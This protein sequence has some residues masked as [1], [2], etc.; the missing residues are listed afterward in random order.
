[1]T[2][3]SLRVVTLSLLIAAL[4]AGGMPAAVSLA[5]WGRRPS[6]AER[7]KHRH[8]RKYSRAWWRR[9]RA[10]QRA[11]R[12]RATARRRRLEAQRNTNSLA[13]RA[14]R[15]PPAEATNSTRE[16]N[17][18]AARSP[19]AALSA[20][21][22]D[23]SPASLTN[24]APRTAPYVALP[25]VPNAALSVPPPALSGAP[26][27]RAAGY[28]RAPA[29]GPRMPFEYAAPPSW[30]AGRRAASGA[31]QFTL[32]TPSGRPAGTATLAPVNLARDAGEGPAAA[33][34]SIGGVSLAVLRRTVID[35]M[36]AEGGW[37]TNDYVR[38]IDGRRVF[39]VFAQT[40]SP[41]APTQSQIFY[42]TEVDGR[43]Y[44]L[45]TNAP[46]E[47]SAPAEAGSEQLLSSLR[48][49]GRGNLVRQQ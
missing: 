6:A 39:V 11:R 26:A 38:E 7:K 37:V 36:V 44:G 3:K 42:F 30:G 21:L 17:P 18:S 27:P 32:R 12:A 20:P 46:L 1:M 48:P 24:V 47:L 15:V 25:S 22:P 49:A 29:A 16:P 41:G 31:V 43:V 5:K 14:R 35:R 19:N 9:Q 2:M 8:Y 33:R 4:V 45:A 13:D 34:K 28:D 23:Y 10:R 40:G